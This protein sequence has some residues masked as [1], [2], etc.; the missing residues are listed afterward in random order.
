M[1]E[2]KMIKG[3]NTVQPS[4][5]DVHQLSSMREEMQ[6][7]DPWEVLEMMDKVLANLCYNT[8]NSALELVIIQ[9]ERQTPEHLQEIFLKVAERMLRIRSTNFLSRM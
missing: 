6:S 9:M 5:Q 8:H 4:V 7:Y 2:S 3:Q 1:K